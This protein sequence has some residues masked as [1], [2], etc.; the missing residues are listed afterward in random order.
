MVTRL[1]LGLSVLLAAC[2]PIQ[3]PVVVVPPVT[4]ERAIA[5]LVSSDSGPVG[6]ASVTVGPH[7]VTS[8]P[9]GYALV[10]RIAVGTH[11]VTVSAASC[12]S[13]AGDH[14]IAIGAPDIPVR[15]SCT[16]RRPTRAKVLLAV[17]VLWLSGK[18]DSSPLPAGKK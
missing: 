18:F 14:A 13:Y 17:L 9:D 3:P 15:L 8:K 12:E 11:R 2:V 10:E 4:P 6:G 7:T 5:V 1:L 16:P